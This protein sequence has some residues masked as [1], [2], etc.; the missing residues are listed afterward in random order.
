MSCEQ[1]NTNK[2]LS[3][4]RKSISVSDFAASFQTAMSLQLF[5]LPVWYL[6]SKRLRS[7][8]SVFFPIMSD[9]SST[10]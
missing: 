6:F 7:V 1:K 3:N 5:D 10:I 8:V 9:F 2:N 4:S